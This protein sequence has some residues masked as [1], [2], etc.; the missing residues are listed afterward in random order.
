MDDTV[1][2]LIIAEGYRLDQIAKIYG[3][4]RKDWC[5]TVER[6]EELRYR[7]AMQAFIR[8]IGPTFNVSPDVT[9][10]PVW[11]PL[12]PPQAPAPHVPD[13]EWDLL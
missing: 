3:L 4:E 8:V 11:K 9:A 5:D 2:D 13:H 7:I 12:P 10:S 1:D 6:D